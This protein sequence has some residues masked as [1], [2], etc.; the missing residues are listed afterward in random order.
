[1]TR[2]RFEKL[3]AQ[4]L[5]TDTLPSVLDPGSWTELYNVACQD[6]SIRNVYGESP[7]IAI[8]IR[9]VYH[10]PFRRVTDEWL[11]VISDGVSVVTVD[12][13]SEQIQNITPLEGVW[14]GEFVSFAN[15]NG[16]LVVNSASDGPYYLAQS[17]RLERLPGWGWDQGW[18]CWALVAFKYYLVALLMSENNVEFQHKL[19]WSNSAEEGA[20]PTEW[21]PST[22][23]DAGDDLLGETLGRLIGGV[24]VRD[25]LLVVKE[26]AV[27]SM[28]HVG[29]QF[30]MRVDRLHGGG[31]TPIPRA[32]AEMQGGLVACT[33]RDV[34]MFNGT[35]LA[36]LADRRVHK[37]FQSLIANDYWYSTQVFRHNPST[38]LWI[39]GA[40]KSH[41][42]L[43]NALVFDWSAN[44]WWHKAL[45][46][47]YGFDAIEL[48]HSDRPLSEIVIYESD[49]GDVSYWVSVLDDSETDS[50]GNPLVC[51]AVRIG[52]PVEGADGVVMVNQAW[53]DID[54]T[55]PVTVTFGGQNDPEGAVTWGTPEVWT[56]GVSHT[57][58]PRVSGRYLAVKVESQDAGRWRIGAIT[59]NWERAGER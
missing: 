24:V 56:P 51:R 34:T 31:G 28:T 47:S 55:I 5:N 41:T 7:Q 58:T 37:A 11:L 17:G 29:G 8:P 22:T 2:Q 16:V 33:A 36:S 12:I 42:R 45:K 46:N 54:S 10:M 20:L 3:G 14:G 9:P 32:F 57:L 38:T 48:F 13:L 59:V 27:Y 6:D 21:V 49:E 26:D 18:R 43:D 23:N 44:V 40:S 35:Q 25:Q 52:L 50:E 4:G 53:L 15:L 19:R 1:M 39:A 30:I